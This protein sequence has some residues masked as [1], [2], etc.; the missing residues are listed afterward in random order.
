M[1][2]LLRELTQETVQQIL[3]LRNDGNSFR[4]IASTIGLSHGSVQ[5]V[6]KREISGK[7]IVREKPRIPRR[8]RKGATL[9]DFEKIS[10]LT[11]SGKTIKECWRNYANEN[12][13]AYT[14]EHFSTLFGV[15]LNANKLPSASRDVRA[16]EGS[17]TAHAIPDYS[18]EEHAASYEFWRDRINPISETL[19]LYGHGCLLKVERGQLVAWNGGRIGDIERV[20]KRFAKI[21]HGISSIV[22]TGSGGS[23]SFEA[24]RWAAVQNI[25]V[26]ILDWYGELQSV[27]GAQLTNTVALRRVQF[28]ADR[29][30]VARAV[31]EQKLEGGRRVGKL[32]RDALA[33]AAARLRSAKCVDDLIKIEAQAALAYWEAWRFPVKHKK[34]NWPDA[35]DQFDRRVSALSGGPR[36]ATSPVNTIL[37]YAYSVVAARCVR[38]LSARGLDPA[39][40][41][42]HADA[43]GR[44]SLAW[45]MMELLRADLDAALLPWVAATTWK[46]ADFPVTRDRGIV[47]LTP[48]L[49]A[50]VAQKAADAV[51]QSALDQAAAWIT[52]QIT[53]E[54][55]RGRKARPRKVA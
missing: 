12:S 42:L 9:P 16:A 51:P 5:R 49:A 8:P 23:I 41:F 19:V 31:L 25:G 44:Y 36:H 35:W 33:V 39:C 29:F 1:R 48:P 13:G 7:E 54:P 43:D 34:R 15:W 27:V 28:A 21:T 38:T 24:M 32:G 53:A 18:T 22:F 30:R 3:A 55:Q 20:N 2:T 26:F 46:R 45:D 52:A 17:Q 4:K 10:R 14:Y 37:N 50:V 11:L 47:R 6:L 40:G